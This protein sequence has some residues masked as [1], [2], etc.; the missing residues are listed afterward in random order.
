MG[1][2]NV[3]DFIRNFR[4]LFEDHQ[5]SGEKENLY[6]DLGT[7]SEC[8]EEQLHRSRTAFP[9]ENPLYAAFHKIINALQN[10]RLAQARFGINELLHLYLSLPQQEGDV[11]GKLYLEHLYLMVLYITQEGFPYENYFFEYILRCYQ[12]VCSFLLSRKQEKEIDTFMDHIVAVG[13]IAAQRQLDT[14]SIHHLL[15]NIETF[16]SERQLKDLAAK[17]KDNRHTLEI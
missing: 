4:K 13:K 16:A 7:V 8:T 15:R 6:L 12:P 9:S 2:D 3:C 1:R 5:S 11:K 14:C 10:N 17:A